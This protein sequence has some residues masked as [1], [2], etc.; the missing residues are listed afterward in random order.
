[1]KSSAFYSFLHS[2]PF[3]L[4]VAQSPIPPPTKMEIRLKKVPGIKEHGQSKLWFS[5]LD[6]K[7][8]EASSSHRSEIFTR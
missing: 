7:N 8:V 6:K 1:M 5:L 2:F 4:S 3:L